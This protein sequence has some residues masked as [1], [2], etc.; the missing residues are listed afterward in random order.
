MLDDPFKDI[1][2]VLHTLKCQN[3]LQYRDIP[4]Q[5]FAGLSLRKIFLNIQTLE[6]W[7]KKAKKYL[8]IL[9]KF[10]INRTFLAS[11]VKRLTLQSFKII[12]P[13]GWTISTLTFNISESKILPPGDFSGRCSPNCLL[14][15]YQVSERQLKN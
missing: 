14:Y 3:K 4:I 11:V 6:L 8:H 1:I 13:L 9:T 10:Q 5:L 7:K 2:H 15:A 12:S